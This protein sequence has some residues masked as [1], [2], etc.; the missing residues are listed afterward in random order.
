MDVCQVFKKLYVNIMPLEDKPM[1]YFFHF[2]EVN[3]N[4][5]AD[6]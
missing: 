6:A 3:I 5:M 2:P 1:H 4:N